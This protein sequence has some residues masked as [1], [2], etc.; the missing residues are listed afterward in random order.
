MNNY[1][2]YDKFFERWDW[3]R[4]HGA[5]NDRL[6]RRLQLGLALLPHDELLRSLA[7]TRIRQLKQMSKAGLLPPFAQAQ[8]FSGELVLGQDLHGS[9]IRVMLDWLCSGLF[10]IA[11]TGSGK[12]NLG[13]W[14]ISQLAWLACSSWLIEPYKIQY[15]LLLPMY[16]QAGKPLVILP[17][18]NWR[19]N[20]LQCE[21]CDPR[22]HAILVSDLLVRTLDIPGRAATIL[23]QGIHTL[24]VKF[25]V[26]EGNA[27]R[28]P[29]LFHLFEWVRKQKDLNAAGR[30]AILDRLGAFLMVITPACA[31]WTRGWT[32]QALSRHS[33]VFEMRGAS[34]SIRTLLPQSLLFSVFHSR[35]A[36]GLMNGP[37]ELLL[38]IDDAQR[39][40]SDQTTSDGVI[41]PLDEALGIVRGAGIGIWP[42]VQTTIGFSRRA[43]ANLAMRTF[44]RLG[45]HDDLAV[46]SA[47]YGLDEEQVN[48][49][50]HNLTPGTFVGQIGLGSYTRPFIFWVPL[51]KLPDAVSEAD[52][53][54]SQAPLHELPTEFAD[55]FAKWS[56]QMSAE[57]VPAEQNPATILNEIELRLLRAIVATPGKTISF[58]CR[59]ARLNG[60]RLAEIRERLVSQG[61]LRE[62][63]VATK[64]RGRTAIVI[65]PL[66]PAI[67]AVQANPEN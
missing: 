22:S 65:E 42:L 1:E 26:Y 50:R 44:G 40:F 56:P 24:Y 63:R 48:Y 60:K 16:Q 37:L 12:T 35:I 11:N 49:V 52:I 9:P 25:S 67:T 66:A 3:A 18:Q 61:Y 31:A 32:P 28:F 47:D 21:D 53:Q 17:W 27:T 19:W 10:T 57:I 62:H 29:T 59:I 15:R 23:R 34:E 6:G 4:A 30:D 46:M 54:L 39:I 2:R 38:V 41:T 64:S 5:A 45:T 36:K 14:L 43:R 58:Y 8:L 7:E 55:D 51:A 33:I 13:Y 20:L